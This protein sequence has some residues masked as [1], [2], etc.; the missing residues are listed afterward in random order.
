MAAV[1]QGYDN[2]RREYNKFLGSVNPTP[3]ASLSPPGSSPSSLYDEKTDADDDDDDDDETYTD[4]QEDEEEAKEEEI[5]VE[6]PSFTCPECHNVFKSQNGLTNHANRM[7]GIWVG[8]AAK[9]KKERTDD[10][11]KTGRGIV[12]Y[13]ASSRR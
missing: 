4:A 8:K 7:H 6:P 5:K 10:G 11:A 13:S 3:T 9:P 2:W 12:F 1:T